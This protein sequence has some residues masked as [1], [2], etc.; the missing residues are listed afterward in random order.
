MR[1]L[2]QYELFFLFS[3]TQRQPSPY[4]NFK[5]QH[6]FTFQKAAN[7]D[8]LILIFLAVTFDTLLSTSK[9]PL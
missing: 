2:F 7:N 1:D 4:E 9:C 3:A 6:K 8:I 5:Q